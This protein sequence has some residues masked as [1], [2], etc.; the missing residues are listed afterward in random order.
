MKISVFVIEN[1]FN[2]PSKRRI[3]KRSNAPAL[4]SNLPSG[5]FRSISENL[6]NIRYFLSNSGIFSQGVSSELRRKIANTL[7]SHQQHLKSADFLAN[8]PL[9]RRL[10]LRTNA[11][12]SSSM[13]RL[14]GKPKH[15]FAAKPK[16]GIYR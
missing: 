13:F 6:Y 14:G 7:K 12:F 1:Y 8:A 10:M 15:A 5:A 9:C 4:R 16:S 2:P 11:I 3:R